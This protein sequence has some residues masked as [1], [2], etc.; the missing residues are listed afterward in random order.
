MTATTDNPE[1][2][3]V[4]CGA[5]LAGLTLAR[6]LKLRWPELPVLVLDRLE[7]PLPEAAFKV[8]ESTVEVGA[9]YLADV[10]DLRDYF[11]QCHL[12]KLGLRFFFGDAAGPFA[13]RPEFGISRFPEVSSYQIDRG[14]LENDLRRLVA[15]AGVELLEG[16]HVRDIRLAGDGGLHEVV[17]RRADGEAEAARGRWVIDAMGRRRL[18]QRKLGLTREPTA[19]H[20]AVWFRIDGRVDVDDLVAESDR[21]WH[22]RVPNRN[23]YFSTNH[24]MG[25]GYWVWTI[26]LSTG[27]TSVGIVT[28]G[29]LHDFGEL[30]TW[31]RART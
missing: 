2:R 3:I 9:S 28:H 20:D 16:C 24:L 26:P 19:R 7:R 25:D 31:E 22:R 10:L 21:E 1:E 11:D 14:L 23:R 8:G 6:Q 5:G 27:H 13:A 12:P 30:N 18:L 4:I 17:Y 15:E 29:G